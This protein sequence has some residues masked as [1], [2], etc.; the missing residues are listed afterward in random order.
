MLSFLSMDDEEVLAAGRRPADL[1][2]PRGQTP[3]GA[4]HCPAPSRKTTVQG[5]GGPP[6]WPSVV[7][8][9]TTSVVVGWNRVHRFGAGS[10]FHSNR[11]DPPTVENPKEHL[12]TI[13]IHLIHQTWCTELSSP[14]QDLKPQ[15]QIDQ[16]RQPEPLWKVQCWG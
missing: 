13:P 11:R 3:G 2:E 1:A 6:P 10:P 5:P 8:M 14:Q 15:S 12:S 16:M 9:H 7:C 4:A